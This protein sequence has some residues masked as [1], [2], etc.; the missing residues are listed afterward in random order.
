MS[1]T[2]KKLWQRGCDFLGTETAIMGGAMSWVSE[3]N[4]VAA[5]SNAGGF[6]VIAS[7]AMPPE[8]LNEEIKGTQAL[9]NKPFGVNLITMHPKISDLIDVCIERNVGHIVLAGGLPSAEAIKKIKSANIK[10][11]CFAP[12]LSIAQKLVKLGADALVIE[13]HE[14]G[15]HIGPVSTSVLAQEILPHL[16]DVPIFVA[17]GIGRG[18]AI[19]TYLKMGASGCQLGTRFVCATESK[20]HPKFKHAFIKA[21]ARNAVVSAQLDSRFPVI[22]VRALANKATQDFT[23]YQQEIIVKVN[24]G[25]LEQK[26]AQL[27]I[28]HFWAGALR[29]AVVEGDIETGSVMAGQS[30]GMVTAEQPTKEIINEL[31]EQASVYLQ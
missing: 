13:G 9:T 12:T 10:L 4:L 31:I 25:E 3:R 16:K 27:E 18:E 26:A 19:G 21:N 8:L 23:K 30:V 11:I 22:P 14:A 15:G 6:G 2:L 29:R 7:G 1:Q 28:E 5:I 24:N 20:A 17:G